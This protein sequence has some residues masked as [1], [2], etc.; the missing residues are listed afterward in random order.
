MLLIWS[1]TIAILLSILLGEL[2]HYPFGGG[3]VAVSLTDVLVGIA[4]LFLVIW[5]VGIQ[6]QIFKIKNF[7]W[8]IIFW[9]VG[10]LSLVVSGNLRGGLYLLRFIL[11][12][13]SFYLGYS[14]IRLKITTLTRI[15]QL[16]VWLGGELAI[17][18]LLQLIFFP[19]LTFLADFGF[20]PHKNRLVSTFLDPNFTGAFLNISLLLSLFLWL[21]ERNKLW[22]IWSVIILLAVILTFSRSAY[23]MMLVELGLFGLLK[24]KKLLIGF[25]VGGMLVYLFISP[26]HNR[27]NGAFAVDKSASERI[28]SWQNGLQAFSTHPVLGVGFDNLR[29]YFD[30][31][32]RFKVFAD[33]TVHSG[34][35]V[36]SSLLFIL[37]TT[38]LVG[39][40][41]YIFWLADYFKQNRKKEMTFIIFCLTAGLLI[42]SQF[43]NSLF[44]PPIM[45]VFYL[46]LGANMGEE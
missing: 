25:L 37:A 34:A 38:G 15:S 11:Y 18:G 1:L 41:V 13:S 31:K 26:V 42:D 4:L 33:Q 28:Y 30:S 45:L 5:Q 20:D 32:N 17:L 27:I 21:K 29:S 43:I 24:W 8:I 14:L 7:R 10:L 2:G 22:I 36:D 46:L 44:Y 39:F 9:L 40:M 19:N 23:L 12:S 35:G 16:L 6:R 3:G